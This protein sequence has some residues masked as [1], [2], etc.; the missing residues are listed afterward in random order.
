MTTLPVDYRKRP[1]RHKY[2]DEETPVL[3]RWFIFGTY[4]DGTV[5]IS[6]GDQDI[7]SYVPQPIAVEIVNARNTFV[8]T[9]LKHF[10]L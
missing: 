2:L 10:G 5:G 6:D 9:V 1:W 8:A 3:N 4:P 7:F